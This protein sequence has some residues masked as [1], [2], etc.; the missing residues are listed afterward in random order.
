[1]ETI[2]EWYQKQEAKRETNRLRQRQLMS[3]YLQQKGELYDTIAANEQTVGLT[4]QRLKASLGSDYGKFEEQ[5]S[6]KLNLPELKTQ[7]PYSYGEK[8][9]TLATEYSEQF[10]KGQLAK[11]D[12]ESTALE[13]SRLTGK[14]FKTDVPF[15]SPA[16][17]EELAEQQEDMLSDA[18]TYI[19]ALEDAGVKLDYSDSD[20][21]EDIYNKARNKYIELRGVPDEDEITEGMRKQREGAGL[22]PEPV[23]MTIGGKPFQ[24]NSIQEAL[25]EIRTGGYTQA[26]I[27]DAVSIL[28]SKTKNFEAEAWLNENL[29]GAGTDKPYPR[30]EEFLERINTL[31]TTYVEDID[32]KKIGTEGYYEELELV[33]GYISETKQALEESTPERK[34]KI[35]GDFKSRF[36]LMDD[37]GESTVYIIPKELS[38]VA[39]EYRQAKELVEGMEA[40][41]PKS[42]MLVKN[43]PEEKVFLEKYKEA[44]KRMEEAEEKLK[45]EREKM[46][47]QPG[48]KGLYAKVLS[49]EVR[50]KEV[51]DTEEKIDTEKV[52]ALSKKYGWE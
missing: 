2:S 23:S 21:I 18:K 6:E 30:R 34:E 29:R 14:E 31:G 10:K 24:F 8:Y 7:Y 26:Q 42:G 33:G 28:E 15:E 17:K 37:D 44:E 4:Q 35:I 5:I 16:Q 40:N 48:M 1:M 25:N 51:G 45:D 36:V 32:E 22:L 41:K 13:A 11:G 43:T 52:N 47:A 3:N 49:E 27:E 9:N 20:S 50:L 19:R 38:D 39:N 46:T 12:L